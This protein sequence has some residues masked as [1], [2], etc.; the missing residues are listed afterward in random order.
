MWMVVGLGNPGSTYARTRHNVGFMV[1][2][3]LADRWGLVFESDGRARRARGGY[4]DQPV[5]LV[6]P[7]VYMNRSGEVLEDLTPED[8]VV[9]VFDDLDL[10]VGRL[11]IRPRGGTGGHR[12]LASMVTRLGET[13]TR[14]RVG[15]GRPPLGV[16]AADY[17]LAPLDDADRRALAGAAERACQAI[18]C[19]I[20][21]GPAAAMNR[22]N[23]TPPTAVEPV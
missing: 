20:T 15:V 14:V 5:Q 7:L 8:H 17:V 23:S 13:F 10:P 4:A 21:E 3:R 19:L 18:E 1:V 9:A 16:S 11:R 2:D 12:G 6:E 22:F